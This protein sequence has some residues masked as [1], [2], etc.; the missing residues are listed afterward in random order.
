M[1]QEGVNW[2]LYIGIVMV[3]CAFLISL[4][5]PNV[6]H[7][8]KFAARHRLGEHARYVVYSVFS[9]GIKV[10]DCFFFREKNNYIY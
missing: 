4:L 8:V 1:L 6:R 10:S 3:L 2:A 9:S 7:L 5:A